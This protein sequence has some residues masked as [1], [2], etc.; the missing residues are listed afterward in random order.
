MEPFEPGWKRLAAT[1]K[2]GIPSMEELYGEPMKRERKSDPD[3]KCCELCGGRVKEGN[4]CD[5]CRE[6]LHP[7][8]EEI[9]ACIACGLP[10]KEN[11]VEAQ[12]WRC[13]QCQGLFHKYCV[14]TQTG[15]MKQWVCDECKE[16]PEGL[17]EAVPCP[18]VDPTSRLL[19]CYYP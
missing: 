12:C 8:W 14:K 5:Q 6:E 13:S 19:F 9:Y 15:N 18:L 1:R 7:S 4:V 2:R 10:I 11:E 17:S 16:L 3:E